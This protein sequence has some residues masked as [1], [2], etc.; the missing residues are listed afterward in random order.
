MIGLFLKLLFLPLWLALE[1]LE[2]LARGGGGRRRRRRSS[3]AAT[4]TVA[5]AI[6]ALA[7]IFIAAKYWYITVP[8]VVVLGILWRVGSHRSAERR[9][10][11]R[12]TWLDGP[13]PPLAFPGRFTSNWF[14]RNGPYLHP[15]H[16]PMIFTELRRR[17]WSAS[18]IATRAQPYLSYEE[19]EH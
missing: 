15:G 7:G 1:L 16:L 9:A 14:I 10:I 13:P 6:V 8:A 12:Q 17:G 11:E 2:H 5:A 18:D 4:P 19:A 3:S